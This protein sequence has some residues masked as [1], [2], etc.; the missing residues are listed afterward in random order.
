MSKLALTEIQ[1]Q[2]MKKLLDDTYPT[3]KILL[4]DTSAIPLELGK[5]IKHV[6]DK[7]E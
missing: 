2:K 7:L 4:V 6:Q 5:G 1:H 3:G